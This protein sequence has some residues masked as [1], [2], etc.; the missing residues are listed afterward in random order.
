MPEDPQDVS[1]FKAA[2]ARTKTEDIVRKLDDNTI[3]RAWKRDLAEAEVARRTGAGNAA[4]ASPS[5]QS[6][7]NSRRHRSA[8]VKGWIV[9][10][11]LIVAAVLA[12][13]AY[14]MP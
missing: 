4:K 9:T 10:I 6:A 11:V 8:M 12:A 3:A 7:Q 5:R 1:K 13:V 14:V 2:L